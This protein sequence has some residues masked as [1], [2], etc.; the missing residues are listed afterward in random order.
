MDYEH[1][2]PCSSFG[3]DLADGARAAD[4]EPTGVGGSALWLVCQGA[5]AA[6]GSRGAGE[7]KTSLIGQSRPALSLSCDVIHLAESPKLA[8]YKAAG[9][10]VAEGARVNCH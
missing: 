3:V 5:D 10:T 8:V 7:G 2:L 1:A 6:A 9:I 4:A